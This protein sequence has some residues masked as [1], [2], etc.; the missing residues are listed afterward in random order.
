MNDFIC[1]FCRGHLRVG[2]NIVFKIR[3]EEKEHALLFLNAK[4][5]NYTSYKH[6]SFI[7]QPGEEIEFSCPLCSVDLRSDIHINLVKVI[8]VDEKGDDY[9]VYFSKVAGEHSTY[10]TKDDE[11]GTAGDDAG[12]YTYFKVGQK[13]KKFLK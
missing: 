4:I 2:E 10:V 3:N 9:D 5:G 1:P 8:M 7:I 12:K 13:F 11:L 6:P